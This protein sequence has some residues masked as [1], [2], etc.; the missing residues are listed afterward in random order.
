M[1]TP[2]KTTTRTVIPPIATTSTP[3]S[4]GLNSTSLGGYTPTSTST[5]TATSGKIPT[6]TSEIQQPDVTTTAYIT[7]QVY[8][9][10]M[11]RDATAAEIAKYHQQF[12][13][14]AK[15]HPIFTRQ[16]TYD[17]S[18]GLP[19]VATRDITAQ[20]NPLAETDFIT[21]IV[22][23]GPESEAYKAATNYMQTM[24]QAMSQFGGG[25]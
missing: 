22:R 15:T 1:A 24:T 12:S 3:T 6:F 2:T 10:L 4:T 21:N 23:Q 5:T 8:Q 14:Y 16:A 13:D 17:P 19:Y 7:N 9:D 11:G 18:T 25:F 20:R